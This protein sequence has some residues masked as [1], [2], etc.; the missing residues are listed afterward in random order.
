MLHVAAF[1]TSFALTANPPATPFID[2]VPDDAFLLAAKSR[3]VVLLYFSAEWCGPCRLLDQQTWP[4]PQLRKWLAE[5]AVALKLDD[6][7]H[8]D[9]TKRFN[10]AGYPTILLLRPDF[11][12]LARIVGFRRPRDLLDELTGAL[13]GKNE[14]ARAREKLDS[15]H[16]NDPVL[17]MKYARALERDGK[18]QQALA[19]YLW[20]F[21]H[22][23]DFSPQFDG[24]RLSLLLND[25]ARLGRDY[26]PAIDA[27][28]KRR[29]AAERDVLP[30]NQL[31]EPELAATSAPGPS[32]RNHAAIEAAA[33]NRT[34][35]D[36]GRILIIFDNIGSDADAKLVRRI[37][38]RDVIDDLLLKS[39]YADVLATIGDAPAEVDRLIKS[40]QSSLKIIVRRQPA[41]PIA[42]MSAFKRQTVEQCC[43]Y[44][45]AALGAKQPQQAQAIA[46]LILKFDPSSDTFVELVE[47]ALDVSDNAAARAMIHRGEATLTGPGL[48]KLRIVARDLPPEE[49]K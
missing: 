1:L 11:T 38:L 39:R 6:K 43:K 41:D 18:Q 44:Y 15:S 34:L 5:N 3:K 30:A 49:K 9:A 35:N 23:A 19:E 48:D 21:D 24:T 28:R 4:D 47:C 13:T 37:L 12:E 32:R 14:L 31:V 36:R 45:Q 8:P 16:Q 46:D 27:I 2:L 20:C 7:A 29:N 42:A 25:V 10:V 33:L 17:R 26:P 22:G 40:A